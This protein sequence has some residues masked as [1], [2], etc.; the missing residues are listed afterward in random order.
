M[1]LPRS[2]RFSCGTGGWVS[3]TQ[4]SLED[5]LVYA[6]SFTVRNHTQKHSQLKILEICLEKINRVRKLRKLYKKH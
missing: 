1:Q 3:E 2:L 4:E 5:I 6:T